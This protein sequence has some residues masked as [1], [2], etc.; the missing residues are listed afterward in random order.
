MRA[1]CCG[2]VFTRRDANSFF[3]AS[4]FQFYLGKKIAYVYRAQTARK[5][6]RGE[7]T[8]VIQTDQCVFCL[9]ASNPLSLGDAF[10]V[11]GPVCVRTQTIPFTQAWFDLMCFSSESSGARSPDPM[12]TT[13][14]CVLSSRRTCPP[15]PSALVCAWYVSWS[16]GKC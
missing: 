8:K 3:C 9:A 5:A 15:R 1:C 11:G 13:V 14:L 2:E 6:L 10:V 7:T 4:F 12:A 16:R